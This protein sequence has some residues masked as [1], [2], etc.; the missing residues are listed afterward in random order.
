MKSVA[1]RLRLDLAQY[2]ELEAFASFASDLDAATKRQLERGARTVEILKQG[3]YQPMPVEQQVMILYA[4]SNGYI[5][6]VA[7]PVLR[8][9]EKGFHEFMSAQ[10]P[11]VGERIRAEKAMSKETEADFKR[12][13]D[14]YKKSAAA[15]S[16]N[17]TAKSL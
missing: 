12:A 16:A 1:G 9:W 11:Q 10:Y 8:E 6:D 2:R 3:Q 7:I 13:L 5:D 15:G 4:V 14:E 17:F